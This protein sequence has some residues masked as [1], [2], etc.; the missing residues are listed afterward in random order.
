M[1][2]VH[3]HQKVS[4]SVFVGKVL[5][6][7][8]TF[9]SFGKV[10]AYPEMVRYGYANCISCHVSPTGGGVLTEYGRALSAEILSTWTSH[11]EEKFLYGAVT[12]PDWLSTG[13]D[14]RALGLFQALG[15]RQ[16]FNF[17]FMQ[18]DAEAAATIG[19]VTLD[20]T[21]GVSYDGTPISRRHFLTYRPTE[22]LSFRLGKFMPA[23]GINSE[24]HSVG[25]KRGLGKDEGTETY[26]IEAA[27]IGENFDAFLTGILGRPDNLQLGAETGGAL[28]SSFFVAKSIKLGASYY[29]GTRDIEQRH[30]LGPFAMVGFTPRLFLLAEAD[31]QFFIPKTLQGGITQNG[32]V[33][34]IRLDYELYQGVHFYL[35]QEYY[36]YD[37][38]S[39]LASSDSYGVGFQW[40]PRPH[41]E[42]NTVYEK[43][44]IGGTSANFGNYAYLMLHYYL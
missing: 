34:D 22:S 26:N 37:F 42:L 7:L 32:F 21:G 19:D 2:T 29:Y 31:F 6:T 4:T 10:F 25:V 13:G 15:V 30:V 38:S 35:L 27:W 40:F 41:I 1:K 3:R 16:G 12:P 23:F 11:D 5:V 20:A 36:T 33:D 28:S 24:N 14:V 39:S 43:Q 17:I 8:L 9:V 18:A 44:R